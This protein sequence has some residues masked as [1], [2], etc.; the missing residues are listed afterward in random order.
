MQALQES[1]MDRYAFV[2]GSGVISVVV[3]LIG[4]ANRAFGGEVYS[5]THDS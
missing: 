4:L 5:M 2:G 1:Y 3:S